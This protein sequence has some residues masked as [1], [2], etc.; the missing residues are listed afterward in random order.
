[1]ADVNLAEVIRYAQPAPELFAEAPAVAAWLTACHAR[2]A[3]Q[4]MMAT[5]NAEPA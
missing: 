5:R 4:A 1:M 3:F 2:P